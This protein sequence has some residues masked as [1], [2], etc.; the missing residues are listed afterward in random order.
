MRCYF[1]SAAAMNLLSMLQAVYGLPMSI[2]SWWRR[3][4]GRRKETGRQTSPL[5]QLPVELIH[6]I[7]NELSPAGRRVLSQTCRPLCEILGKSALATRLSRDDYCEYLAL[8][9]RQRPDYWVC[10]AC[11]GFHRVTT[12]DTPENPCVPTCS[13][14]PRRW[15][16][17]GYGQ[18]DRLD[19]RLFRVDHRH[20]QL[21]LKYTRLRCDNYQDYLDKLLAPCVDSNFETY[22]WPYRQPNKLTV[23]YSAFPKI[24]M[25]NDGN[26]RFLLLSTWS[27][28][29]DRSQLSLPAMGDL[30]ICPHLRL[31]YGARRGAGRE[32][33]SLRGILT[34][35]LLNE[36][37]NE[38]KGLYFCCYCP[39]DLCVK[40]SPGRLFLS[41][42]QDLGPEGSP[43]DKSWRVHIL[44][45]LNSSRGHPHLSHEPGSILRLYEQDKSKQNRTT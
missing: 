41:A 28:Q 36:D 24:V 3:L 9:A 40:K 39:T 8:I 10:E 37:S 2:M 42:W 45:S 19:A 26:L 29:E 20:I 18:R 22:L 17:T 35:F 11:I 33:G 21:A 4:R 15:R 38:R 27:Y 31:P 34:P 25:G 1:L 6:R 43:M 30:K 44:S 16:Y 13:A 23:R 5:L 32:L 7:S 14:G 12:V